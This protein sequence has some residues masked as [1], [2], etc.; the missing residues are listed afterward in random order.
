[1]LADVDAAEADDAAAA[2]E[3]AACDSEEAAAEALAAAFEAEVDAADALLVADDAE[4][5][6]EEA[7]PDAAEAELA[8]ADA[9]AAAFAALVWA[10]ATSVA[11]GPAS[12]F[13]VEELNCNVRPSLDACEGSKRFWP[14]SPASIRIVRLTFSS[15]CCIIIT[16][17]SRS[18]FSAPAKRF[19]PWT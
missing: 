16:M 3:L 8:A 17:L 13:P 9:E 5:E 4:D 7:D 18:S 10:F 2:S 6:A 12:G 15:S 14:M 1:M 19:P 11:V